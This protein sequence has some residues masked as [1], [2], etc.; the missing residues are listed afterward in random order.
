MR[1]LAFLLACTA[2][3]FVVAQVHA[4][5]VAARGVVPFHHIA[6]LVV[7]LAV[8]RR[9][10]VLLLRQET[11]RSSCRRCRCCCRWFLFGY[12]HV[13]VVDAV[14]RL[15]K[16]E[17]MNSRR[18]ILGRFLSLV[19]GGKLSAEPSVSESEESEYA[20]G[21][22]LSKACFGFCGG[23][24]GWCWR[25]GGA[26]LAPMGI[27]MGTLWFAGGSALPAILAAAGP[28][29]QSILSKKAHLL[30]PCPAEIFAFS[31]LNFFFTCFCFKFPLLSSRYRSPHASIST[32][33]ALSL[34]QSSRPPPAALL[35]CCT[36]KATANALLPPCGGA[37]T[38]TVTAILPS[39]LGDAGDADESRD[40]ISSLSSINPRRRSEN[41]R[42]SEI[43]F[44]L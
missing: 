34:Q 10:R 25:R 27:P 32:A 6:D 36:G 14:H 37:D 40:R 38:A 4:L 3:V 8:V 11:A 22:F 29:N 26:D 1:E 28:I 23:G 5:V 30:G 19:A 44:S 43:R 12:V 41:Q 9:S 16:L 31:S 2:V 7:V 15:T 35:C 20:A 42:R 18:S 21:G 33:V 13:V 39:D 24:E 17:F